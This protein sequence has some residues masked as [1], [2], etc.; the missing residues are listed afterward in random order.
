MN[1]STEERLQR[2]ID[3][4]EDQFL[5]K[6]DQAVREITDYLVAKYFPNTTLEEKKHIAKHVVKSFDHFISNIYL[7]GTYVDFEY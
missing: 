3:D 6:H 1:A 7:D 4:L 2:M 5:V